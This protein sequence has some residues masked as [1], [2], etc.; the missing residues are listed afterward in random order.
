MRGTAILS[1]L[2]CSG[3]LI[4]IF[5]ILVNAYA[6][7]YA[8]GG[9]F[10]QYRD[11]YECGF[12]AVPD[13]RVALDVQFGLLGLI[14]LIYDVEIILLAPV[15]LNGLSLPAGAQITLVAVLLVLGVSY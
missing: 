7:A 3:A 6:Y 15:L 14:F 13:A 9:R 10:P 5:Y 11:F 2:L 1:L 12:K 4:I 8:R